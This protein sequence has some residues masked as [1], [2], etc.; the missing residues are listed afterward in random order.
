MFQD[1]SGRSEGSSI[2]LD[3]FLIFLLLLVSAIFR[4]YALGYSEYQDDE[5]KAVL[6]PSSGQTVKEFLLTRRKGPGQFLVTSATMKVLTGDWVSH[7]ARDVSEFGL[8]LPFALMNLVSVGIVYLAVKKYTKDPYSAFLAGALYGLNGFVIAFSRIAQYQNLNLLFSSLSLYFGLDLLF[9]NLSRRRLWASS[10]LSSLFFGFSLLSHW[11][12]IYIVVPLVMIWTKFLFSPAVSIKTRLG[13]FLGNLVLALLV[14]APFLVP[15]IQT[16]LHSAKN[17][18]YFNRRVGHSAYPLSRH[19][20][21]FHLY[22]PYMLVELVGLLS[23]VG[24]LFIKKLLPILLWFL[25]DFAL[26]KLFMTKPGTHIYNYVLPALLFASL[27]FGIVAQRASKWWRVGLFLALLPYLGFFAYQNYILFLDHSLEY[28]WRSKQLLRYVTVP[29]REKEVLTFGFPHYR[30]WRLVD[31]IVSNDPDNCTYVTNEGKEISQI[32]MH[33]K[34][35]IL[36]KRSCH[37]VVIVKY[38]FISTRDNYSY[39]GISG[40]DPVFRYKVGDETLTKVYKVYQK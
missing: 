8:R 2:K 3:L 11:D 15:Y 13:V 34:Y 27:S 19:L 29:Y 17:V 12:A 20:F 40:K 37:Y 10:L 9:P 4:F 21:I 24:L 30:A 25:V 38:P 35:G 32:Y 39:P 16:Q 36:D 6:L 33:S 23:L 31:E 18:A 7:K 14:V 1:A 28:P 26:I 22:N 5:K